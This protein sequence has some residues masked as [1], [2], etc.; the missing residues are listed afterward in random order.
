[1]KSDQFLNSILGK[2]EKLHKVAPKQQKKEKFIK[3]NKCIH[4]SSCC[5]LMPLKVGHPAKFLLIMCW[6]NLSFTQ[7]MQLTDI[8]SKIRTPSYLTI[9]LHW[10]I[11]LSVTT[12]ALIMA[13]LGNLEA[14]AKSQNHFCVPQ[15]HPWTI[16]F[17]LLFIFIHNL[18]DL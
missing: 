10:N 6:C 17:L 2:N 9:V 18:F 1:M 15:K 14:R 4:D 13:D 8:I 3:T 16:C 7:Q 5:L 12:T 11:C